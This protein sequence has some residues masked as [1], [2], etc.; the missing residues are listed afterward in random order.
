NLCT[1]RMTILDSSPTA[2]RLL[3]SIDQ[4]VRDI[5]SAGGEP[6]A[7]IVGPAAYETLKTAVADRFGRERAELSQ[8][9][10]LPVVV[11]PFRENRVCVV[12]APR[13]VAAGV[14][15]ERLD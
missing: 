11:D 7:L 14:R 9:Q 6:T 10:W 3:E 1:V 12:P 4:S 2:D 15:L 8:Y 5:Q 13:D